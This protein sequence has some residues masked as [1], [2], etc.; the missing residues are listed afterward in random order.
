MGGPGDPAPGTPMQA[1]LSWGEGLSCRNAGDAGRTSTQGL[2][3]VASTL[4]F[5]DSSKLPLK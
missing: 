5:V 1:V 4:G 3:T 2:P